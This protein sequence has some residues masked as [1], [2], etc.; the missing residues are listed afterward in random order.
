MV[1]ISIVKDFSRTPGP[2]YIAEG[3]HSGELF[4][5]KH[6]LPNVQIAMDNNEDIMIDLDGA[7]GYGTSFLEESFGGLVREDKI[8]YDFLKAHLKIKSDE[9][10]IYEGEIWDYIEKAYKAELDA[11]K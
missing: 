8:S 11:E 9:D 6:L 5:K 4:R 7:S 3:D 2:R 1:T 10:D